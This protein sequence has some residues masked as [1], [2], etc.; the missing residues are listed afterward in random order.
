MR[1]KENDFFAVF[2][3]DVVGRDIDER[4]RVFAKETTGGLFLFADYE[5]DEETFTELLW[6]QK[7]H[8][9]EVRVVLV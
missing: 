6:A 3:P 9:V 5:V 2:A 8:N 4:F 1:V 7:S